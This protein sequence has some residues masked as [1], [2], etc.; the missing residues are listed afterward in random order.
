MEA[1]IALPREPRLI[2]VQNTQITS[3]S[4]SRNVDQTYEY[5]ILYKKVLFK[6]GQ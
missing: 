2:N 1:I 5:N 6:Q 3:Q 4:A